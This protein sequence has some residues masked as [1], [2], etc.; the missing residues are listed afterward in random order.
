MLVTLIVSF[1]LVGGILL[2]CYFSSKVSYRMIDPADL[3]KIAFVDLRDE[4]IHLEFPRAKV[5][6]LLSQPI[7]FYDE[8][9][10]EDVFIDQIACPTGEVLNAPPNFRLYE[11]GL[12]NSDRIYELVRSLCGY[13]MLFARQR[14]YAPADMVMVSERSRTNLEETDCFIESPVRLEYYMN[15]MNWKFPAKIS[16]FYGLAEFRSGYLL[17]KPEVLNEIDADSP[18]NQ[19]SRRFQE[20]NTVID[21]E[22]LLV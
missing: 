16:I 2:I 5:N 12:R 6:I 19:C 18:S 7:D 22:S 21:L 14:F 4:T 17:D 9:S 15:S 10:I 11:E 1:L 3:Y 13:G 8:D 20:L